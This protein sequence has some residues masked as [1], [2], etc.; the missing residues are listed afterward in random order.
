MTNI[1]VLIRYD[2][3]SGHAFV[4]D[5][6][7]QISMLKLV[8]NSVQ[9]VTTFKGHSG[10]VRSLLWEPSSSLLFSGSFDQNVC[11]WDI[12]GKK[13]TV[14][15]LQGHKGKV[16][17]LEYLKKT[18]QLISGGED[19]IL[20]AWNMKIPR[21]ET[22]EWKE[23]DICET[24]RKPFFWNLRAM[25]ESKTVGQRQHHCRACG[26]AV[27][28]K[29]SSRRSPLPKMGFEFEVRLCDPCFA[30]VTD[31]DRVSLASFHEAKHSIVTLHLDEARNLLVTVG[32]DKLIKIWDIS[33]LNQS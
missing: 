21:Q 14:Y 22:P 28:D 1:F 6:S 24:C 20:V 13:G 17:G 32:T 25:I 3:V 2:S 12:G 29:C 15:E 7:G 10:S 5:Y 4:G 31:A 18:N 11:V 8:N 9:C 27:C 19:A 23:S 16:T 26:K 30:Q 33:A